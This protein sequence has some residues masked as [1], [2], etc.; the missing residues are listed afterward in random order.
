M[1][2]CAQEL[3]RV[4][5]VQDAPPF[6]FNTDA[7]AHPIRGFRDT[8]W[9]AIDRSTMRSETNPSSQ[10]GYGACRTSPPRPP[11][12]R[13]AG[14]ASAHDGGTGGYGRIDLRPGEEVRRTLTMECASS[15]QAELA[16]SGG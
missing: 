14:P 1:R 12:R 2:Q 4:V 8:I 6:T 3:R 10:M 16:G 7:L 5:R 15:R 13:V 9:N 11:G